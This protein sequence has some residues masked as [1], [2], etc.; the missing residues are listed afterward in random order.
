MSFPTPYTVTRE[1][2][3]PSTDAHGSPVDGWGAP[4]NVVVHGWSPPTGDREPV[5]AGRSP[6]VRDLDVFAP[7]GTPGGPKDRWTVAGVQYLQVGHVEDFTTGPWQWAAGVRINLL[8][9]E[10]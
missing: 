6:V 3:E 4:G 2:Y 8:R 5:E 7:A 10:G 9:V 1:A